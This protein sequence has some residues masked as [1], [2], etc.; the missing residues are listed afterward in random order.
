VSIPKEDKFRAEIH[1]KKITIII[2][3]LSFSVLGA[4]IVSLVNITQDMEEL[5]SFYRGYMGRKLLISEHR[6]LFRNKEPT[7]NPEGENGVTYIP[8]EPMEQVLGLSLLA[9]SRSLISQLGHSRRYV[10]DEEPEWRFLDYRLDVGPPPSSFCAFLR[11]YDCGVFCYDDLSP[12]ELQRRQNLLGQ[13][14][15]WKKRKRKNFTIIV[16]ERVRREMGD[17]EEQ[18]NKKRGPPSS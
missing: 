16:T 5:Q 11:Q 18:K 13:F 8:M 12:D 3:I 14:R 7:N 1:K 6:L 10:E 17:Q 15:R 2:V 4:F 9:Y